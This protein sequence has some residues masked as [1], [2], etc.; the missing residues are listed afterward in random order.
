M[1]DNARDDVQY[2]SHFLT[3]QLSSSPKLWRLRREKSVPE[4]MTY[5]MFRTF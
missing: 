5:S 4:L 2:V 1:A 3:R